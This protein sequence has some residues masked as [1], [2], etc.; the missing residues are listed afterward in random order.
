M[1]KTGTRGKRRPYAEGRYTGHRLPSYVPAKPLVLLASKTKAA[2]DPMADYIE[3]AEWWLARSKHSQRALVKAFDQ[4]NVACCLI[5]RVGAIIQLSAPEE[6]GGE[7]KIA[8]Q[9]SSAK[10]SWDVDLC[11]S[12]A[13][14]YLDC[15]WQPD[16]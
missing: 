12:E 15:L 1:A 8:I 14:I 2:R 9:I 3:D 4:Q 5:E 11:L 7:Y 16:V 6:R 10:H 13:G